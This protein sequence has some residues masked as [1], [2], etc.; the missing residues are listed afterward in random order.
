M[1]KRQLN[2]G[3][4]GEHSIFGDEQ[5]AQLRFQLD[6]LRGSVADL[7]AGLQAQ[8]TTIAAHAEIAR[9]QADF[10]RDEGRADLDRTRETLLG[11]MEQLREQIVEPGHHAPGSAPGPSLETQNAR[12]EA[13]ETQLAQLA[14][15]VDTCAR[16]QS[17]LADMVVAFLDTALAQQRGE[18]LAGL[19]LT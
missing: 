4:L 6:E 10:A 17:E 9:Q 19:S 11:L 12:V 5:A 13:I 16:R 3:T 2:G 8:F 7:A 14:V 1:A 15:S 18:P